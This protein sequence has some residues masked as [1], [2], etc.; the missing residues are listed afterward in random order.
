MKRLNHLIEAT[1]IALPKLVRKRWRQLFWLL[2]SG[3]VPL[4]YLS[5]EEPTSGTPDPRLASFDELM[6]SFV[7]DPRVPGASLAVARGER[8]I[9]ARGYGWANRKRKEPV[10]PTSL[11]RI[12]S[13]SKPVTAAA[14]LKLVDQGKLDLDDLAVWK[15]NPRIVPSEAKSAESEIHH[16]TIRQLLNHTA[17]FDRK[18]S[19]DPMFRTRN[20]AEHFKLEKPP[21]AAQILT[22]VLER[23]LDFHPGQ[24]YAY[25]NLGYNWLG[26]IIEQTSGQSYEHFVRSEILAPLGIRTMRLGRNFWSERFPNEVTYYDDRDPVPSVIDFRVRPRRVSRPYGAWDLEAMDAHGGWIASAID[27]VRFG[28]FLFSENT[29]PLS[30]AGRAMITEVPAGAAGHRDDG[31]PKQMYYGAGWMVRPLDGKGVNLWHNGLL[32]GTSSLLVRRHDGLTW[33]VL[34]NSRSGTAE[35]RKNLAGAIDSLVHRAAARVEKWPEHK[36]LFPQYTV[37]RSDREE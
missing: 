16:I 37:T 32:D 31:S 22:Y 36:D 1:L 11:F 24:R 23:P 34:F 21:T 17:G 12:A 18:A 6:L 19:F 20:I 33:A 2:L 30:P 35:D 9:L 3:I 15:T 7:E 29:S 26:R 14:I 25:S 8:L 13:I 5:A 27:L 28:V 4:T 10:E